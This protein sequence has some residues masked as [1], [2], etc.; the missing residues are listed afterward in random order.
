MKK[1][2]KVLIIEDQPIIVEIVSL[3]LRMRWPEANVVTTNL[4]EKGIE[5]VEVEVPD[6]VILDLGLPDMDGFEVLKQVRLFSTVPII[7]LTVR[8]EE[9]DIVKGLEWGADEYIVKPFRQLEL[10]ARVQA[11]LRRKNVPSGETHLVY[12]PFQLDLSRHRLVIGKRDISLTNTEALILY[13][14]MKNAERVVTISRLTEI[15][16]GGDYAGAADAIRVY[17]RRLRTKIEANPSHPEFIHTSPGLVY[18]L[19]K[20]G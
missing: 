15:L 6:V 16:W 8:E 9:H 14:L 12:G 17:I 7:I 13:H 5:L 10:M 3:A 18:T 2:L 4:G 1:D 11:L 19:K 20:I